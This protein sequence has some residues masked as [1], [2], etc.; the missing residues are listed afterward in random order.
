[1]LSQLI[2]ELERQIGKSATLDKRPAQPGDVE[3]TFADLS[4][5]RAE[6]GYEPKVSLAEGLRQF[7]AWYRQYGELYQLPG[8]G[9]GAV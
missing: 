7:V 5:S 8:E 2:A 9:T 6:L 4:R 1:M 3:R